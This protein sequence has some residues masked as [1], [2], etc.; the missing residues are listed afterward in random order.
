VP[1]GQ[2]PDATAPAPVR[3]LPVYDDA[4]L[5]HQDRGRIVPPDVGPAL[6][7]TQENIGSVLI[8]GLVGGR[9]QLRRERGGALLRVDLLR[10]VSVA[11]LADLQDEAA[12]ALAFM[13]AGVP[14]A[15][16]EVRMAGSGTLPR[17]TKPPGKAGRT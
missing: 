11:D 15:R 3:F 2:L 17:D 9:W 14:G 16:L 8:D 10:E 6:P 13:T 12:A 7:L 4:V 5:G 1:D